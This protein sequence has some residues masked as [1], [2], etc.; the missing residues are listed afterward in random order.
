MTFRKEAYEINH[1][2][3]VG[4]IAVTA[5]CLIPV[6]ISA[7]LVLSEKTRLFP[8]LLA[9]FSALAF[10]FSGILVQAAT[11]YTYSSRYPGDTDFY[12]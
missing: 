6:I 2:Y 11:E 12:Q 3:T 10:L 7:L 8:I 9:S 5:S 4:Q 1:V